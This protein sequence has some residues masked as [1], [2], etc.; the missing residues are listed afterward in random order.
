MD[1]SLNRTPLT[2]QCY[3]NLIWPPELLIRYSVK[4]GAMAYFIVQLLTYH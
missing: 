2:G 3:E 4:Y 1:I